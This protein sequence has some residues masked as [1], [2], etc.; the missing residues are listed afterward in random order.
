MIDAPSSTW[1]TV[2]P[3]WRWLITLYFFFG[4]LAGGCYFLAALIDLVGRPE[5][6]RLARLGYYVALPCF[7]VSGVILIVDLSRPERFWHLFIESNTWQPMFKY[8]SPMSIGSWVLL[9]FGAFVLVSFIAALVED[10]RLG[11]RGAQRLRPPGGPGAVVAVL[12][13]LLGLYAAGYTGV[14]L[15]VTNRP[16]WAD[17]P[18]LGMLFVV[19]ATSISAA[20]MLLLA[21]RRRWTLPGIAALHRIDV[22][23]I[24][25]ELL[26]LIAVIVSLGPAARALWNV[27]G[28][29][30]L[31]GVVG[32]GMIVPLLLYRRHDRVGAAG[33]MVTGAALVLAGGFLLRMVIL[34]APGGIHT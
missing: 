5:D 7:A 25:L 30:L 2:D 10:G 34:F 9:A 11:W 26:V 12:G 13:G 27:W 24:A 23:A 17:T 21:Q 19:S 20:L 29:V 16:L 1:F 28:L 22:W 6:R 3:H 14:L 32:L 18:L 15:A 31:V 33:G 4:G 8:W